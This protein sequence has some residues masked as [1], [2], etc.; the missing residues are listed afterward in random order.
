MV[1]EAGTSQNDWHRQRVDGCSRNSPTQSNLYCCKGYAIFQP[2]LS[3]RQPSYV[4]SRPIVSSSA[5]RN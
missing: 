2:T 3:G 1:A 4:V 5:I